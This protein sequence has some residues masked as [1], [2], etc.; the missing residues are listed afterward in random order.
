M[1]QK[2]AAMALQHFNAVA[3]CAAIA[4]QSMVTGGMLS[5]GT[6]DALVGRLLDIQARATACMRKHTATTARACEGAKASLSTLIRAQPLIIDALGSDTGP[7]L[8]LHCIPGMRG[9]SYDPAALS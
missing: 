2:L 1:E 4:K 7:V 3:R 8:V 5:D 6:A 9:R